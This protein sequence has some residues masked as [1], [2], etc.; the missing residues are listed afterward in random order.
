MKELSIDSIGNGPNHLG[1]NSS[2]FYFTY[3][4]QFLNFLTIT[5][6]E[7]DRICHN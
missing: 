3:I 6:L 4:L 2:K 1:R 5:R 7:K